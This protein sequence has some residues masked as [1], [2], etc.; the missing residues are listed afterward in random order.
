MMKSIR[1]TILDREYPLKVSEENEER[2][3]EIVAAVEAR[4]Q[5]HIVTACS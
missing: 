2:T 3:V 4:M 5:A 1:I